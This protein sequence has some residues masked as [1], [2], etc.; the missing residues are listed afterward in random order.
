[1]ASPFPRQP[2]SWTRK[3]GDALRGCG[4]AFRRQ[5]SFWVHAGCAVAVLAAGLW[6]HL[7]AW[8]WCIVL[9]CIVAVLT[10]EMLNTALE[11]L[12]QAV[13]RDY[14]PHLRDALDMGSA[15][16]LL[17]AAGAVVIGAVVFLL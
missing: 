4:I 11:Q 1:M 17:A 16:V 15:A 5:S 10:A 12:A 7:L 14:N 3:F 6:R 9:L 13:D 2:R 8:Q